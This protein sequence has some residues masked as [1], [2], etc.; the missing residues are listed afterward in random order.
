MIDARVVVPGPVFA[1][2]PAEQQ[3]RLEEQR[4]AAVAAEAAAR[5]E[6]RRR[7]RAIAAAQ[8]AANDGMRQRLGTL[9]RWQLKR[10][11]CDCREHVNKRGQYTWLS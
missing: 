1:S 8:T 10:P 3:R 6:L 11:S 5:R 7:L 9:Q 4:D 2:C